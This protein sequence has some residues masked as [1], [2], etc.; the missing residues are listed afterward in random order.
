MINIKQKMSRGVR[1]SISKHSFSS[2]MI[3][4]GI[5]L[6]LFS[7]HDL[8]SFSEAQQLQ[9][10]FYSETCPSAESIVGDVV[11]QA[12]TKDPGNAAVLLRLHFHDCFVEVWF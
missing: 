1:E 5:F 11:K 3:I 8:C 6:V 9:F 7:A 2:R 4:I 10:G 12:V